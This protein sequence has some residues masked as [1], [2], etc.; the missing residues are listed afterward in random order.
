MQRSRTIVGYSDCLINCASSRNFYCCMIT[1][2][3]AKRFFWMEI[4]IIRKD[5]AP[6]LVLPSIWEPSVKMDISGFGSFSG[7]PQTV[8]T[9]NRFLYLKL[10]MLVS[11]LSPRIGRIQWYPSVLT[12]SF[13]NLLKSSLRD[14]LNTISSTCC[15]VRN[16][17]FKNRLLVEDQKSKSHAAVQSK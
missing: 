1:T 14:I 2:T 13:H 5:S 16:W 7:S 6:V 8:A 10:G 9:S 4:G 3:F 17:N 15:S 12:N 11:I